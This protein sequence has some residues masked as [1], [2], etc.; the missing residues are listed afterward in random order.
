MVDPRSTE[1]HRKFRKNYTGTG[2][3]VGISRP[4]EDKTPEVGVVNRT[5][6]G[7]KRHNKVQRDRN[8]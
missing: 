5:R 4:R 3:E 1:S 2:D 8:V 7:V 6:L